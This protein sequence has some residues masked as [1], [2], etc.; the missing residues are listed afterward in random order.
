MKKHLFVLILTLSGGIFAIFP[1]QAA[2]CQSD[3]Q[4]TI[5]LLDAVKS[6][7]IQVDKATFESAFKNSIQGLAQNKC[8]TELTRLQQYI[9]SEKQSP[10]A[11]K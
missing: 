2:D 1:A 8:Q 3:Y 7:Q 5:A 10:P 11:P 9:T 6:R 4:K